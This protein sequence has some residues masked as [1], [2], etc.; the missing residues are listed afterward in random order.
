MDFAQSLKL[1]RQNLEENLSAENLA[2]IDSVTEEVIRSGIANQSLKVGDIIP[3][4]ALPNQNGE[5]TQIKKFCKQGNVVISFYRGTWCPFCNLELKALEQAL[6]AINMLG[7]TL[8]TISPQVLMEYSIDKKELYFENLIDKGNKI[9]KQ[10]GIVFKIPENARSYYKNIG[11]YLPKYNGDESFE[12]P[13]AATFIINQDG[14]I[15][16]A[17]VEP[18]HTKRLDPVEIITIMRKLNSDSVVN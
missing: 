12:L 14:I 8:V 10:F 4:F 6:P 15:H 17:F 5:L 9:A 1:T 7:G 11:I 13:I 18:D 2:G 3:D 16:Y